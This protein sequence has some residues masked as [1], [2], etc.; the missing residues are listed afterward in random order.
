MARKALFTSLVKIEDES[1]VDPVGDLDRL[2]DVGRAD[3]RGRRPED[4]LCA[5]RIPGSTSPKMVGR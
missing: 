1:P 3:Q 5:I 2:V 4:L